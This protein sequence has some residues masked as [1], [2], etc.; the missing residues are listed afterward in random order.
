[1]RG[2]QV[3]SNPVTSLIFSKSLRDGIL[4]TMWKKAT[5]T[6]IHKKGD[7]NLC[8]NYR[9]VSLTSMI[10][11]ML[12]TIIKGKLIQCFKSKNLLSICQHGFCSSHSCVTPL[13]QAVND[14]SLGLGSSNSV[15]V[16]Y[17]DLWQAY[18]C[19]PHR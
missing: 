6:A 8:N 16:V 12:E 2:S 13:L 18:D 19:V 3:F 7:R 14:W 11:K 17:L 10:I 1:M 15:D 5:V 4:P 9:S